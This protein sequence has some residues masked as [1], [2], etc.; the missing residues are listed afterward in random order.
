MLQNIPKEKILEIVQRGPT[1]PNRIAKEL[2][3]ETILIGAILS[4]L[5]KIGQVKVSRVKIGASPIY[6]VP[7]QETRL[8]EFI[9]HLNEKDQRT[10]KLLKEKHVLKDSNQDPLIRVSLRTI[11]DFAKP[12]EIEEQGRKELYWKYF[13]ATPE[14]IN[15]GITAGHT[16]RTSE[17]VSSI[18]TSPLVPGTHPYEESATGIIPSQ[19]SE[20]VHAETPKPISIDASSKR[21]PAILAEPPA[22]KSK[23]DFF[24]SVKTKMYQLNLDIVSKEKIKK[25]EYTL[26]VK[27]HDTN[28]YMY[29]VAK[30]KK[31]INE[32][33]ISTAFVYAQNKKMP[34]MFL[35]TGHLT[36]KAES[37]L[38]KEFKD[39]RI[40][41]INNE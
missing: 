4:T 6:Y 24:E 16:T 9:T 29:C 32:G 3:T 20:S 5:I 27:N 1:I 15:A 35:M 28:E 21:E 10:V 12:F 22:V 41:K 30:D 38:H 33:D 2:A 37:M 11:K 26:V 23:I 19:G 31:A 8:E 14:E 36:K 34:C 25:S 39:L 40:E 18:A 17:I 7:E 13:I